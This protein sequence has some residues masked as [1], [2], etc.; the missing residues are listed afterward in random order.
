MNKLSTNNIILLM[1]VTCFLITIGVNWTFNYCSKKNQELSSYILLNSEAKFSVSQSLYLFQSWLLGNDKLNVTDQVME[2]LLLVQ[3]ELKA[4]YEG[5]EARYYNNIYYTVNDDELKEKIKISYSN[6]NS[7]IEL[8]QVKYNYQIVSLKRHNKSS[9]RSEELERKFVENFDKIY[10]EIF[11]TYEDTDLLLTI[12]ASNNKTK[13]NLY[14]TITISIISLLLLSLV[15]ILFRTQRARE[16]ISIKYNAFEDSE[17]IRINKL[18]EFIKHIKNGEFSASLDIDITSDGF[19]KSILELKEKL[20][21]A[22]VEEKKQHEDNERRNWI[23]QGLAW[24]SGVLRDN[25]KGIDDLSYNVISG[26]VKYLGSNQ[27]GLFIINE[28][29]ENNKFLELTGAYAYE[30]R[31]YFKKQILVGEGLV[32][33]CFQETKSVYLTNLPHDYIKITSGL[34]EGTPSNIVLVP[35]IFDDK[36]YG[37]IEIA[38]FSPIEKHQL[39]FLENVGQSIAS[40]IASTRINQRTAILLEQSRQ[41]AEILKAQEEEM[42]QNM[43]EMQATQEE[44]YRREAELKS[45]LVAVNFSNIVVEYDLDGTIISANEAFAEAVNKPVNIILGENHKNFSPVFL[46]NRDEYLRFW[47]K[48]LNGEQQKKETVLVLD[49]G[50]EIKL[51]EAFSPIFDQNN[52]VVKIVNFAINVTEQIEKIKN[53]IN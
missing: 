7:L 40:T 30:T 51:L 21:E 45:M 37:V 6:L 20:E 24:A 43:E 14:K 10:K 41:Q 53:V 50:K 22:S 15:F 52:Q 44:A 42:R 35:L 26:L 36:C 4:A 39:E 12:I 47:N 11:N 34:G 8:L 33:M 5:S 23:T 38:S 18:T 48:L 29:D 46:K 3:R 32:G 17:A 31:K 9:N 1:I 2:P 27:G 16:K 25:Y 13:V 28:D 19:A 49:N